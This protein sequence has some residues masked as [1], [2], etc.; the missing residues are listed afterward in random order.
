MR[1]GAPC[2]GSARPARRPT[3]VLVSRLRPTLAAAAIAVVVTVTA[4]AAP[5]PT[6]PRTGCSRPTASGTSRIG[7]EARLDPGSPRYVRA[8]IARSG[9]R[10]RAGGLYPNIQANRF[11]TPIY[12]VAAGAPRV[13]VALDTGPWGNGLRAALAAGVPIPAGATP[14][15]G[16]DG[17]MTVYQPVDRHAV[18]VL[19]R[20]P[21]ARDGWRASWGGAIRD[22]SRNPGYYSSSRLAR[23]VRRATAGTGA[24]PPRS[25]PVAAGTVTRAELRRG[26]IDHALA[27][28]AAEPV[29][30][31]SSPGPRS[32]RTAPLDDA[33]AC[34]RARACGWTPGWTWTGSRLPRVTRIAGRGRPAPRHRSCATGP[35]ARWRS[36]WSRPRRASRSPYTGARG[37]YRGVPSWRMLERFPWHRL[38]VL[39]LHRCTQL[40]LRTLRPAGCSTAVASR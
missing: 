4:A 22:V 32:A 23:A 35:A 29:P 39:P 17:H 3:R 33:T 40:A 1:P 19:A 13:P 26:R 36:T 8:L 34:P 20:P 14:A 28:A 38:Q 7:A 10:S 9:P 27:V 11:S 31:G 16:S 12:R 21:P 5:A 37:L 2:G 6:P 30:A 25:L 18:G 24:R 15:E